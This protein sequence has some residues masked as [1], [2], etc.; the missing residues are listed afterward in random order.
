MNDIS[1][2]LISNEFRIDSRL[3]APELNHRH[4]TILESLDK[5]KSHFEDH[6]A[7][8]FKTE[9]GINGGS[10]IRYFLLNEDQCC[11]LLTLMRNNDFVVSKKSKLVKAFRDARKQLAERDIA[12]LDGKQVRRLETDAIKHL[13]EYAKASGSSKPEMYYVTLTNMTNKSLG[14]ESGQRDKMDARQLQLLKIAETLVE[15]AIRDGLKAELHYKDIYR[16]CKDR[17]SDVLTQLKLN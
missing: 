12:R 2:N 3:L 10:P 9:V 16:L 1:L 8:P 7:L 13:V 14:I 17:V 11:F 6:G 5:Y 4:R 15:I